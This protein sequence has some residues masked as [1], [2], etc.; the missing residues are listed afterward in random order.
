[1]P[2]N[3]LHPRYIVDENNQRS[4]VV[5]SLDEFSELLEDLE[6]LAMI[7]ERRN[8]PSVPHENVVDELRNDGI[9]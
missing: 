9:L 4:S 5:L 2:I 3:N 6:D 8:E 1:M 7:A